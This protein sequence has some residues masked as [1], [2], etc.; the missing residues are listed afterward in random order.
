MGKALKLTF[1]LNYPYLHVHNLHIINVIRCHAEAHSLSRSLV[2]SLRHH[3]LLR[4]TSICRVPPRLT[5]SFIATFFHAFRLFSK[6]KRLALFFFLVL[7]FHMHNAFVLLSII[8]LRGWKM[9]VWRHISKIPFVCVCTMVISIAWRWNKFFNRI[10]PEFF[11]NIELNRS[12]ATWAVIPT[13]SFDKCNLFDR[14]LFRY[15]FL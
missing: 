9:R 8:I 3:Q 1:P 4:F 12:T 5:T 10:S 7:S 14:R 11:T 13:T 2:R 15:C 6:L